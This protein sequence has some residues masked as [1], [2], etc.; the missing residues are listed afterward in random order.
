MA[1]AAYAL[2][3][4]GGPP[5]VTV[6]RVVA[7]ASCPWSRYSVTFDLYSDRKKPERSDF[8]RALGANC[9][10]ENR[11]GEKTAAKECGGMVATDGHR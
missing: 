3:G 5:M 7:Q 9:G 6:L 11:E 4:M 10:V 1:W 2:C 8:P